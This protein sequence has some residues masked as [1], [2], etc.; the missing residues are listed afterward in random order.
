MR[1]YD[2]AKYLNIHPVRLKR[3]EKKGVISP[4]RDRNGWR[5]YSEKDLRH[6][7]EYFFPKA[8]KGSGR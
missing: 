3:L 1:A 5:K 2:V 8:R 6:A 7:K 4:I